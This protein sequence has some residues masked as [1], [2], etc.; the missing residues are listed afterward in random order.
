M[1]T[2]NPTNN[3]RR[4][5]LAIAPRQPIPSTAARRH[6]FRPTAK[7]VRLAVAVS[8]R[9]AIS[10]QPP[11]DVNPAGPGLVF[12]LPPIARKGTSAAPRLQSSVRLAA[13]PH[14][15]RPPVAPPAFGVHRVCPSVCPLHHLRLS[16]FGLISLI[17]RRGP[18][19]VARRSLASVCC[20][21]SAASITLH[22]HAHRTIATQTSAAAAR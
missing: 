7:P 22:T 19:L 17:L 14:T 15:R 11:H 18:T 6:A 5:P 9:A 16:S 2:A 1:A 13:C 20:S 12:A 21:S 4:R 10:S 3:T 8:R